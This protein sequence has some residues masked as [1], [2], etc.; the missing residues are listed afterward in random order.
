MIV[1]IYNGDLINGKQGGGVKFLR[2]LIAAQKKMKYQSQIIAVNN[3]RGWCDFSTRYGPIPY[4]SISKT[5][6]WPIFLL[7]LTVHVLWNR[8]KY[9][10]AIF[11]IHRFYFAFPL[12]FVREKRVVLSVLTKTFDVF[13]TRFPNFKFLTPLFIQL[14]KV[15]LSH[16]ISSIAPL[17]ENM[18]SV[19]E[20][21]FKE[22]YLR[23]KIVL[24][25]C[26]NLEEMEQNLIDKVQHKRKMGLDASRKIFLY[27][28]RLSP[29]KGVTLLLEQFHKFLCLDP[30]YPGRFLLLII[31]NGELFEELRSYVSQHGLT[32]SVLFLG[33]LEPRQ[34]KAYYQAADFFIFYSPYEASSY[35][36]KEAAYFGL[37]LFTTAVGDVLQYFTPAMGELIPAS[38]IEDS[39][40]QLPAF[41]ERVYDKN[42]IASNVKKYITLQN[43]K[44]QQALTQIYSHNN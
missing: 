34:I 31:G 21:R 37:P 42:E 25:L 29:V 17:S 24:P 40:T 23:K 38:N 11:H 22:L 9:Q 26:F 7:L 3:H 13:E 28:G 36:L 6:C 44:F 10:G 33:E 20:S 2:N 19:Y 1:N 12:I 16:M 15:L 41:V 32:D 43:D 14:E 39:Y 35:V 30:E 5:S 8:R 4:F 27:V 18:G